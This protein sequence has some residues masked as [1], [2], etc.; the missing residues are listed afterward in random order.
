[1]GHLD[2]AAHAWWLEAEAQSNGWATELE[3]F[4]ASHPRPQLKTFLVGLKGH[5][6]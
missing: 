2:A 5:R 6:P 4:R 3:E 1:M